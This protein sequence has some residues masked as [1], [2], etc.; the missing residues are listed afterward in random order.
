MLRG[1]TNSFILMGVNGEKEGLQ[2][3]PYLETGRSRGYKFLLTCGGE[4]GL[5]TLPYLGVG[6]RRGYK[7][8]PT[9]G[10]E[11]GL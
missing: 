1:I 9:C 6:R 3:L 2:T 8:I 11:E 4:E 7:F 10:E 5:Q